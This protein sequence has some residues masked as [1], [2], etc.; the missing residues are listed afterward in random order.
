MSTNPGWRALMIGTVIAIA[1]TASAQMPNIDQTFLN[2]P[3]NHER[4]VI[5]FCVYPRSATAQIDRT[6]A[7]AL[8]EALLVRSEIIEVDAAIRVEGIDTIPIALEDLYILLE[9]E[10]NAFMGIDLATGVY[11]DWLILTRD[12]LQAPYVAVTRPGA[13]SSFD[14]LRPGDAVATQSMSLGD[15]RFGFY[16]D[17]LPEQ[18]RLRRVPYPTAHLQLE[19]LVDETVDAALVWEPWLAHDVVPQ[20]SIEEVPFGEISFGERLIGIGLH[21]NDQYL[22]HSLDTAIE[23]LATDGTIER[24]NSYRVP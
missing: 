20:G 2:A 7:Q 4:D 9:N 22:R 3:S 13:Y 23:A 1:G 16:L 10:C 6:V 21:V 8:G 18:Q 24:I 14:E 5:R 15:S 12:Y 17:T 19:R 11:P